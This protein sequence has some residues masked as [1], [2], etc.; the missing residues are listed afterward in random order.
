MPGFSTELEHNLTPGEAFERL[1]SFGDRMRV[2]YSAHVSELTETW[3]EDGRFDFSFKVMGMSIQGNMITEAERIVV[4]GS[5][6]FT[7]LPFRG[8]L[9]NEIRARLKEALHGE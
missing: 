6:P 1:K 5:L 4:T 7:A 8:Q 2:A 3:H 9:E